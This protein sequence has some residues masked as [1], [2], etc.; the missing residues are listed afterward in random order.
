LIWLACPIGRSMRRNV[1]KLFAS[2]I[3]KRQAIGREGKNMF[4]TA[5]GEMT[6]T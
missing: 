3:Q 1:H 6:G 5:T 2:F 4:T